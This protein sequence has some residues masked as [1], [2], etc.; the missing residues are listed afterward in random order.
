M[1]N[2]FLNELSIDFR[3]YIK[4]TYQVHLKARLK[5]NYDPMFDHIT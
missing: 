2:K 5:F 4:I 1:Y 3:T